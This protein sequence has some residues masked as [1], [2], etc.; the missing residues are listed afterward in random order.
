M[1]EKDV[2]SPHAL[3][4]VQ[5]IQAEPDTKKREEIMIALAEEALRMHDASDLG[6]DDHVHSYFDD[7]T[8][9]KAQYRQAALRVARLATH[10]IEMATSNDV[11]EGSQKV[12]LN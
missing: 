3:D 6:L 8:L 5:R 12:S 4:L 11:S 7:M 9:A 2:F 1:T 10:S